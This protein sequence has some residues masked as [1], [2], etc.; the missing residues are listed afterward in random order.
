MKKK[1]GCFGPNLLLL[2]FQLVLTEFNKDFIYTT[3]V[4]PCQYYQTMIIDNTITKITFEM[5]IFLDFY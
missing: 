5:S 4:S 1:K 2:V 3:I